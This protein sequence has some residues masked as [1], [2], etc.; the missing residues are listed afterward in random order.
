MRYGGH[1]AVNDVSLAAPVGR[2]TGLIGPNGAGKTTLFNVA[3][4]LVR[5]ASGQL[6][7]HGADMSA[8]DPAARARH[9]LGRT[10]QKMEL[11]DSLTARENVSL[12]R[13]AGQ[14]GRRPWQHVAET[15]RDRQNRNA[16]AE[17]A[18]ALAGIADLAGRPVAALSTGQRR[19]VEL[20]RCLAGEFDV[21]L[22]DEPSS[23]LDRTETERFG[24]ILT[25]VVA[26]RGVGI[27]LVEHDMALVM[28]ICD[29]VHV[30]DFGTMIFEGT[31]ADVSASDE[32]RAAY[33]GAE[34]VGQPQPT[35]A[36]PQPEDGEVSTM[37]EL[38]G[39]EA[40]Y[41]E[42]TVLRDVSLTVQPGTVVAVLGPN[43]A[44]KT[45]LL[46]VAS[47]LLKPSTGTVL[48]DGEDVTRTRPYAR[49]RR[50]L[51]HIPEGRGIYPTL[52]VR[53]NLV[54]HSHQGEEAAALDRATSAFPVLGEQASPASRPVVRRP[55]ADA[56][57]G[58]RLPHRSQ[59]GFG[60]RG[61]DGAG[62]GG[63]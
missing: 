10:F 41:G 62:P 37:L 56:V 38:R 60:G 29:Y 19:L 39:I 14:A 32:V 12:G 18:M 6:R 26:E 50:G 17:Q 2:I 24:G 13:E 7:L 43:G 23:G 54:L 16:A 42:H 3:S 31:T 27:L 47:G 58:P 49:A 61:L 36:Q 55:A 53:E 15:T 1:V 25:R 44:G 5:P 11:F 48:L 63:H 52:T 21:L 59:A 51:C 4:G 20:A 33:L 35:M 45:T 30:L 8:L 9:G 22:L 28:N 34:P 57:A 40:G 46:R